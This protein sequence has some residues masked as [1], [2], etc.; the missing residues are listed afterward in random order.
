MIDHYDAFISYKHAPLDNKV[1]AHVQS[2]LEHFHIP[3][4]I[5]K[6]TGMKRIQRVFRDKDELPITSDLGATISH[7]LENSN[8]LIVICS[9]NTRKSEWVK[10]EIQY[11]LKYHSRRQ[12]LAVLA[13]GEPTDVLP[14]ELLREEVR[15]VRPD[16][17]EAIVLHEKEPLC[18][19]FR[20]SMHKADKE[21]LPRLASALIGC[22]YDELM[23]RRRAYQMQ[24]I[25]ALSLA[26]VTLAFSVL[27]Y[28]IWNRSRLQKS[29]RDTL[30]NQAIYRANESENFLEQ[31]KRIDAIQM[32]LAALPSEDNDRPVTSEAVR[33]LT[34]ATLAYKPLMGS[35][36]ESVWNYKMP[37]SIGFMDLSPERT[38][39]A[40][41]DQTGL[42]NVWRTEDHKLILEK[43]FSGKDVVFLD[44]LKD[45]LLL[46]VTAYEAYMYRPSTGDLAWSFPLEDGLAF[47]GHF[48]LLRV[49][50]DDSFFLLTN[51]D[52]LYHISSE[53]G[54]LLDSYKIPSN[55]D[56]KYFSSE[57]YAV[58]PDGTKIALFFELDLSS[59]VGIYDLSDGSI[60]LCP[61][62][63][64]S[65]RNMKWADNETVI[66]VGYDV[67]SSN[68]L[69][70]T[71]RIIVQPHSDDVTCIDVPSMT[72]RW[73]RDCKYNVSLSYSEILNLPARNAVAYSTGDV[74]EI[75][76]TK[77][78][79]VLGSYQV[80]QLIAD[81]SDNDGDGVPTFVTESGALGIPVD[82]MSPNTVTYTIE[83]V[84]KID[85]ALIGN[86][87]YVLQKNASEVIFYDTY[88]MDD[89]W[90]DMNP[91]TVVQEPQQYL[92]DDD[93][94]VVLSQYDGIPEI[95]AYDADKKTLLLDIKIEEAKSSSAKLLQVADDVLYISVVNQESGISIYRISLEDGSREEIYN[96]SS[97]YYINQFCVSM[98]N[99]YLTYVY[100]DK[101]KN[102]DRIGF[103]NVRSGE[104]KSFDFPKDDP[105]RIS[106]P[107]YYPELKEIVVSDKE[108]VFVINVESNDIK[109]LR[110]SSNWSGANV[111]EHN[112]E[113]NRWIIADLTH[114]L[115]FDSDWNQEMD[116]QTN[117]R[118]AVGAA[119]YKEGTSSEQILVVFDDGSFYRYDGETGDFIGKS[120]V[121][122]YYNT[123]KE[124]TLTI[125]EEQGLIFIQTGNIT[126]LLETESWVE[127]A[128]VW[129]SLGYHKPTDTFFAFSFTGAVDFHIGYF[130]HYTLQE[131]KD[132]AYRILKGSEMS[133]EQKM[134]YGIS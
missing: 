36:I 23:N 14:E 95:L 58:S 66:V 50:S 7:A 83:F 45:D 20:Q 60:K 82:S 49:E 53:D 129:N 57:G 94:L 11:F 130:R 115:I 2:K 34:N 106:V 99:D 79:D 123:F 40:A 71:D 88:V 24:R 124:A 16:G 72:E 68:N 10:R 69:L 128:V 21:E 70:R 12:I 31:E 86:G 63:G 132:K 4:K 35:S 113:G 25:T 84:N 91:D 125:D 109:Q 33:A 5:R 102:F 19:D 96:I 81:I 9:H 64:T 26:F 22:S 119:F 103:Y 61:V 92:L 89:E 46:V 126:D 43:S 44:Y 32:A 133:E 114:V 29:Y 98:T 59:N 77:T 28:Q 13:E 117:G 55:I 101:E 76:D 52:Q 112:K 6:K 131:L 54:T 15:V 37:T 51:R 27:L 48:A 97:P 107:V 127:V 65:F 116:L 120:E 73:S 100:R 42:L 105:E 122:M 111:V 78:G 17:T 18:A 75:Y 110:L 47:K 85:K 93:Y 1:A 80:Q 90:T 121:E 108:D 118:A 62:K 39:F 38:S 56:N 87:V 30:R 67:F 41:I 134:R 74:I 104:T 3:A 8:Y